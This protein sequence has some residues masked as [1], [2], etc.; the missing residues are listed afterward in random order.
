MPKLDIHTTFKRLRNRYRLVIMNDDSFEELATF[1]L[2]RLSVYI[3]VTTIFMLLI[4]ATV[5]LLWFTPLKQL[6]PGYQQGFAVDAKYKKLK[7]ESDSVFKVAEMQKQYIE[8]I[9]T[10]L[11]EQQPVLLSD[12][13]LLQYNPK[14]TGNLLGLKMKINEN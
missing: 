7:I 1:K 11:K 5:A 4:G 2:N 3:A 14:D 8:N 13:S 12:T 9:K 10:I 6:T